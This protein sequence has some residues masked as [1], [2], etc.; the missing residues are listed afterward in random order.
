MLKKAKRAGMGVLAA[1]MIIVCAIAVSGN[2][3]SDKGAAVADNAVAKA[4]PQI[5][6]KNVLMKK[7]Q[8]IKL[9]L[10]NSKKAKW[11]SSKKSV[12]VV[13]KKGKVNAKAKGNAKV[14]AKYKGKKYSCSITV[15]DGKKKTAVIYFSATGT[16]KDAAKKVAKATGSD[17]IRLLP[18]K[19]YSTKDLDYDNP[20]CRANK[21]QDSSKARPALATAV[22]NLSQYK[23]IYLGYPIWWGKE[24]KLIRTFLDKYSLKGKIVVPFCTSGSSG[25]SGSIAGIKAGAK[26]AIVKDGRD[27]TDDSYSDVKNWVKQL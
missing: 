22:K 11:T 15:A 23:T 16:T 7:G 18:K 4:K 6:Y 21:E 20:K 13:T 27:L 2:M 10:K 17:I 19:A 8:S 12:A 25:I 14:T 1:V 26:G 3:A 5:S 9:K 24:P